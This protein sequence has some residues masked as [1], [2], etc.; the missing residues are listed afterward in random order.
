MPVVPEPTTPITTSD[1]GVHHEARSGF[2]DRDV[3][4]GV[5]RVRVKLRLN[6]VHELIGCIDFDEDRYADRLL[7]CLL[8]LL[9]SLGVVTYVDR[10]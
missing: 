8:D 4:R 6:D 2:G 5:G 10:E 9:A 7:A 1:D 3:E